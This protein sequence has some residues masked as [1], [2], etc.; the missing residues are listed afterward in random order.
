MLNYKK[1]KLLVNQVLEGDWVRLVVSSTSNCMWATTW[2]TVSSGISDQARHKPACAA[3]E[4][5]LSLE[6]LAIE[7]KD[8]ILSKQWTTKVLI[9]LRGCASW[10]ALLLSAYD[11]RH[12]FSWPGSY[13][14]VLT[15]QKW[16][17]SSQSTCNWYTKEKSWL[18]IGIFLNNNA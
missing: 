8:I 11:L 14:L 6:I 5:S 17:K 18:V 16:D 13:N 12:V 15:F 1:K 4:T 2:Q 3:T 7:S 9:R 10:S